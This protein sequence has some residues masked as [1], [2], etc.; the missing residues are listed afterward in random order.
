[1]AIKISGTTVIDNS[2]NGTNLGIVTASSFV[3]DGSGLTNLPPSGGTMTATASGSISNG[4]PVIIQ[5]DGK[6]KSVAG[7]ALTTGQNDIEIFES[8]DSNGSIASV[9]DS[10]NKKI[11]TFYKDGGDSSKLKAVVGTVSGGSISFGTP[12]VVSSS[13]TLHDEFYQAAYDAASGKV[14][15]AYRDR[16]SSQ[17]RCVA[18]VGTVSGTSISFGSVAEIEAQDPEYI[19]VGN[20][21]DNKVVIC[22]TRGGDGRGIIG[23]ISGTSISFGSQATFETGTAVEKWIVYDEDIG[24][25]VVYYRDG[26]NYGVGKVIFVDGT[27][28]SYGD[29]FY[30]NGNSQTWH[31]VSGIYHPPSKKHIVFGMVA[32][33]TLECKPIHITG[34]RDSV[35]LGDL[36]EISSNY[37]QKIRP[38][39]NS[40]TENIVV[41]HYDSTDNMITVKEISVEEMTVTVL[42]GETDILRPDTHIAAAYDTSDHRTAISFS[43]YNDS[44]KGKTSVYNS[45]STPNLANFIGFSD[46]AYTD[47][48]TA[49]IQIVSSTD[50]AQSSLT[51]GSKHYLQGDGT[52]S[53]TPDSPSVLAG[54]ALSGT[55]IIIKR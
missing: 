10:G 16:P 55:E 48:N 28:I 54:T 47:G 45:A 51:V 39:Y 20:A 52:L 41:P 8:G 14:V 46:A 34:A 43:D 25:P 27:T 42:S 29:L 36:V 7:C 26:D 31:N 9:Y 17:N 37:A 33:T 21:G 23:T 3:G 30:I 22:W 2:R 49:T 24:I 15:V 4:A 13:G 53:T 19:N 5:N 6:V 12:V 18:V 40:D 44:S 35:K 50:D 1:M 11:V 32:G 38:V